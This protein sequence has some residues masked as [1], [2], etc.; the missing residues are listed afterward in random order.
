MSHLSELMKFSN[1][2]KQDEETVNIKN[3]RY[4]INENNKYI[5]FFE[6]EFKY[7]YFFLGGFSLSCKS[8][9]ESWLKTLNVTREKLFNLVKK[10]NEYI[11]TKIENERKEVENN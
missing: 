11:T 7:D 4:F 1:M 10:N 5:E 2:K 6:N 3:F 8:M 9:K